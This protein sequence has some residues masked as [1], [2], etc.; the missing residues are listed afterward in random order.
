[1]KTGLNN[2]L[3]PTKSFTVVNNIQQLFAEGEVI[4]GE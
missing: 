4:I 1:M 3:L 2:A